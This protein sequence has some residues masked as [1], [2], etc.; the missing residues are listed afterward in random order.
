M[1]RWMY[2]GAGV[3]LLAGVA[4]IAIGIAIAGRS[5]ESDDAWLEDMRGVRQ[6]PPYSVPPVPLTD[7]GGRAYNLAAEAE[8]KLLLV[9]V[10]YTNCPDSCPLQMFNVARALEQLPP[11]VAD[12]VLVA[13]VTA[14]PARDSPEAL[15][16]WLDRFS[17]AFV[18]L[19]AEQDVVNEFQRSI[20]LNPAS[21]A[22]NDH[23]GY[24]VNH[25]TMVYAFMPDNQRAE[26]VYPDDMAVED[27]VND[28]A[29]LV[30][31]R[32]SAE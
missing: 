2:L 10:G 30:R 26:F 8:G 19:T 31:E 7:T 11:D 27:Y 17:P 1:R 14:D 32:R 6:L 18:G 20:G 16:V 21:H 12:Q 23:G 22:G 24:D 5:T 3:A 25:G 13:F 4:G 15:R 9:Y 29:L 28:I